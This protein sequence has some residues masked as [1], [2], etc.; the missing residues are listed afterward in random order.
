VVVT[1]PSD[2]VGREGYRM[3]N[4]GMENTIDE[5][6][7]LSVSVD[8]DH[9]LPPPTRQIH[10]VYTRKPRCENAEQLPVQEQYQLLAHVDG[11]PTS[12]PPGNLEL[13]SGTN[14]LSELDSVCK[15]GRSAVLEQKE[16]ASTS[17]LISHN[18]SFEAL[19]HIYKAFVTS[20][21]S[22]FTPCEWRKAMQDLKWKMVMFEEM[23]ALVKNDTWDMVLRP[24]G[25]NVVGYKWL[26]SVKYNPEGKVN[27]FKTRLVAKGYTQIYGVD[28]EETFAPVAK[29][30]T[31]RTLISYA[32]NLGWDLCQLDVKNTFLH[33]DLKEEVFM[34][35]PPGFVNEQLRD[36]VCR[37]K[38]SLYGLK[39]SPRAWFEIFSMAMKRLGYRQSDADHIMFIQRKD[40]KICI[41][42]VYMDDIV[43]TGNDLAEM[44]RLKASLAKKFEMK[45]LGELRYFLGIEVARSKKG[46]ILSQQ[47]YVLDL[48]SDIGMLRCKPANTPID[49]NHKLSGE[50]GNQVEKGQYQRLVGR[51]IYLAHTRSDISYAVSVVSRYMHDPR[52]PH[53]ET[54]YQI[55]RYLNGCPGIGVFF[56]KMG[57][58][59]VEVYTDT[60]WAGCLDD[61]KSTSGYCAFVGGNLV[62]W[63]SKKQSVVA[64]SMV[65]AEYRAM[66]HGVGE[67][68]WLRR[69][70]MELG[71]LE[72][73][74]IMLYYDNKATI[75]IANN[76][77]QH[78]RTK[79][80]EI[81]QH[82]I[83]D[84][85]DDGTVCMPFVGTKKQIADVFTKRL[86]ITN[87]SN[88][89]SK[90]SMINIYASS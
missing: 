79:H 27:I 90:M 49:T 52:I 67:G 4:N 50:R 13:R 65:E 2:S 82:F 55:L 6:L 74:P 29:I 39:Q 40:E 48:L 17:H 34:E 37:L 51:L 3:L 58:M 86:G 15:E 87:F 42:I 19:L 80:V 31:V 64:M 20:L 83:K 18:V 26:Y 8:A 63:R 75:N 7:S 22:N 60:D 77:I 84:K 44:K 81:D 23:R 36:K 5:N 11:S 88:L 25:K 66:A 10:K 41:L 76:P 57:H 85:L 56:R 32:V 43:L 38:R 89:I 46:V 35:I 53:L 70:L 24:S 21:H 59:R 78:D 16:S 68:L 30:N 28:Y 47:R 71:L 45:D 72:D 54:V 62:S 69:L 14:I 33:G 12:H 73:K 1:L 9:N 61:R